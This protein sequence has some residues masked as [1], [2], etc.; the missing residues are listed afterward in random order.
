MLAVYVYSRDLPTL[1]NLRDYNPPTVSYVYSDDLT[2]LAE[3]YSEHRLVAPL[4]EIPP[5]VIKAFLAAED[6]NYYQHPGIDLKGLARAFLANYRAGR[7]VQGAST[8]TQ[9]VIKTF[10]LSDERT[11]SRKIKEALLAWRLEKNL[12]KDEILY[13][14]LNRIYLG[15]GAYGVESAAQLYFGKNIRDV[16]LSEAAYLAALVKAPGRMGANAGSPRNLGRQQYIIGQMA[17]AGFISPQE[18]EAGL[19]ERLYFLKHRPNLFREMAPQFTEVV[20]QQ[21]Q[22]LMGSEA[23]LNDGL[24]VYSTLDL[25]AQAQAEEALK[26]G[27][28]A[29][30]RR[31]RLT[32]VSGRLN[33]AETGAYQK[34]MIDQ[35]ENRPLLAGQEVEVV[36]TGYS[37]EPKG[38]K[39]AVGSEEGFIEA[40]D[41]AWLTGRKKLEQV[42]AVGDLLMAEARSQDLD[43]DI[44]RFAPAPP[45]DLQGALVLI[46]NRTGQVKALVG[47]RDFNQN[48]FNRAIQAKRQPGSAFKPIVYAAAIDHGYTQASIIY[49]EPVV[50]DDNGRPWQPKNY[51]GVYS[52][53][54]TLYQALVKSVNVVSVK[55]CEQ[56]TPAEVAEYARRLGINSHLT[57][58][59]SL[60]LGASEVTL[61]E[62]AGAYTAFP[63][64]GS[65]VWPAFIKRIENRDG[66]MLMSFEPRFIRALSPETAY[67]VLDMMVGV[68]TKGTA[69]RVGKELNRPVAGKTGTTN[70]QADAW[71]VGFTPEYTCGVWVGRDKRVNLGAG[72]QGGRTAAPIFISFMKAF[73]ED[74]PTGDFTAPAGVVRQSLDEG[75]DEYGYPVAGPQ[76][77]FKRDA[78][79][80]GRT[81]EQALDDDYYD[82]YVDGPPVYDN[83]SGRREEPP[84]GHAADLEE[85]DRRLR[86]I[87]SGLKPD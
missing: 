45:A 76:Y 5:V 47:G 17:K 67:I 1:G 2:P 43:S 29:L 8:I 66:E 42:F 24:K 15:R 41:L 64:Q 28:M 69:A 32:P 58:S 68:T 30:V 82:Y 27:L 21:A 72:E 38:L 46:E 74:K 86:N 35:F 36:V 85:S 60:G 18:A 56:V 31:Q 14:Y 52:G 87:L 34:K 80:R 77:V 9:Q 51:G 71:F 81:E 11:Y 61:L 19:R 55:L 40:A 48:Q 23:L 25:T 6:A 37:G 53:P 39:V 54:L 20:R 22:H 78:V 16:N 59:L 70:D 44:W 12:S 50:Y 83:R 84:D 10:V 79:G 13:L 4:S 57:P 49:D 73:L 75:Y 62:L 7:V 3:L 65:W 33:R 26:E 63:N